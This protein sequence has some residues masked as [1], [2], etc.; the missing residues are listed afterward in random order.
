MMILAM[1][2]SYDPDPLN[3]TKIRLP[4]DLRTCR[5]IP[6]RWANWQSF[7]PLHMVANHHEALRSLHAL[8]IEVGFYDQYNIQFGSRQLAD[9]LTELQQ[10]VDLAAF[11]GFKIIGYQGIKARIG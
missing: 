9:R 5:L 4:F 10:A 8:Y 3:G 11:L 6:E 1:A 7:D 2:A